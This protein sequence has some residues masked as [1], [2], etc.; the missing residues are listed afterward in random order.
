VGAFSDFVDRCEEAVDDTGNKTFEATQWASVVRMAL[1]ALNYAEPVEASTTINTTNDTQQYDIPT[2]AVSQDHVEKVYYYDASVSQDLYNP[3]T[4]AFLVR[5]NKI[6]LDHFTAANL[7][8][9]VEYGA[10][11]VFEEGDEDSFTQADQDRLIP[12]CKYL[13]YMEMAEI[14]GYKGRDSISDA[15]EWMRK[16]KAAWDAFYRQFPLGTRRVST[17]GDR[18]AGG[19]GLS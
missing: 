18:T 8:L 12:Y 14:A 9:R 17:F 19:Y 11:R 10:V 1:R 16:A 2:D 6:I 7:V 13:Y 5:E 3:D 4:L 15:A